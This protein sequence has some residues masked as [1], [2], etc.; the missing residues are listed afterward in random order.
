MPIR[1]YLQDTTFDPEHVKAMEKAFDCVIRELHDSGQSSV[2]QEVIA[3][4]IIAA[5]K[6]GERDPD[7]LCQL[8]MDALG[9]RRSA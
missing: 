7:K 4:R 6:T 1:P 2:V 8:A 5:A 9:V 3:E